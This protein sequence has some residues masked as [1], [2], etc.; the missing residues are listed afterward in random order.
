M[1]L[2]LLLP[3]MLLNRMT[4]YILYCAS[5]LKNMSPISGSIV[6]SDSPGALGQPIVTHSSL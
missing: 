2:C 4:N 1:Y 6:W 5:D 3:E